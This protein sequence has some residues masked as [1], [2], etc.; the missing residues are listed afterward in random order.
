MVK[1]PP[2]TRRPGFDPWV[3]KISWKRARQPTPVFLPGESLWTEEPPSYSSGGCKESDTTEQLRMALLTSFNLNYFLKTLS[4]YTFPL[5]VRIVFIFFMVFFVCGWAILLSLYWI[6]FSI[7]SVLC[8]VLVFFWPQGMWNLGSPTR[9]WIFT[10]CI[11]RWSLN[12]WTTREVPVVRVLTHWFEGH[13]SALSIRESETGQNH[14]KD[15]KMA[16]NRI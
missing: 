7:A 3:V 14:Q 12:H 15:V 1:N 5:G 16:K 4:P 9:D 8:F 6:C 10:P 2:A 11:E 13:K